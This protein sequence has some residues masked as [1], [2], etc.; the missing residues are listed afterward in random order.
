[1]TFKEIINE[2]HLTTRDLLQDVLDFWVESADSKIGYFHF[3]DENTKEISLGVWSKGV[4]NQCTTAHDNHYPLGKAGVWADCIRTGTYCVHNEY[5]TMCSVNGLPKG[6]FSVHRH[7]SFPLR[8]SENNIVAVIGIGNADK[9]YTREFITRFYERLALQWK[10]VSEKLAQLDVQ[11]QQKMDDFAEAGVD[12]LLVQMLGAISRAIEVRDQGTSHHQYNVAYLAGLI[13]KNLGFDK[14]RLF[15]LKVAALIHDVGKL[16][17]PVEIM[18]KKDP[19]TAEEE[20]IMQSH[21]EAGANIFAG[22]N[23]PWPVREIIRQHHERLDGSG[24]PYGLKDKA[25]CFEARIIA[26]ADVFDRVATR[27][28]MGKVPSGRKAA[29]REVKKGRGTLYDSYVV[30]ALEAAYEK[31]VGFNGR[32]LVP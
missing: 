12:S 17:V 26:V 25:I 9:P 24:Y 31:D 10:I 3:F 18:N 27:A 4:L 19:L 16:A 7:A 13:G 2:Q 20:K 30:D 23:F 28:S 29:M 21:V 22:V 5:A 32:Y 8:N 15:G 1:M 14:N 6:H 11:H